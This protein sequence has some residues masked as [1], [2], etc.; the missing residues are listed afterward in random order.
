[1]PALCSEGHGINLYPSLSS[2]GYDISSLDQR[3]CFCFSPV[4][5]AQHGQVLQA[6]SGLF[7]ACLSQNTD[8]SSREE[9]PPR[10]RHMPLC[11]QA[12]TGLRLLTFLLL[13]STYFVIFPVKHARRGAHSSRSQEGEGRG[14]P[15]VAVLDEVGGLGP[16][17]AEAR[18]R[19]GV[20]A[21]RGL[22]GAHL[23]S[24]GRLH[25]EL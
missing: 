15:D 19:D 23:L 12:H 1:M 3:A 25:C 21:Q 16:A 14:T 4:H 20:Q 5:P 9:L 7:K 24:L 6:N 18:A 8:G 22:H 17:D 11:G 10:D 2:A 13:L